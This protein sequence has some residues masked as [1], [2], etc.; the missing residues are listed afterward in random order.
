MNL[1][2]FTN[3]SKILQRETAAQV[4]KWYLFSKAY[5]DS[6]CYLSSESRRENYLLSSSWKGLFSASE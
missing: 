5:V 2:K 6:V 4:V 3:I 1:H